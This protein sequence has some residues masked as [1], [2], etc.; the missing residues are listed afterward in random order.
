METLQNLS[1]S[2]LL[3]ARQWLLMQSNSIEISK[4][5]AHEARKKIEVVDKLLWA[6]LISS[7]TPWGEQVNVIAE[8]EDENFEKTLEEIKG[9]SDD[10]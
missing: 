2:A 10:E 6:R 5:Y 4:D 8:F 1:T 3:L 9:A 7:K